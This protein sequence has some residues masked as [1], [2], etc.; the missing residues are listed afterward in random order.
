MRLIAKAQCDIECARERGF[1]YLVNC[2]TYPKILRSHWPVPGILAA[3]MKE[4]ATLASGARRRVLLQD[5][6]IIEEEI[7]ELERPF[8]HRY[9]WE[10]GLK[11]P[12]SLLVRRGEAT[13]QFMDLPCGMRVLWTYEL[14]LTSAL[15]YPI[16]KPL[17]LRFQSWMRRGLMRAKQKLER[18]RTRREEDRSDFMRSF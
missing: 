1:D 9:S 8:T 13:W 6:V 10:R 15:T 2:K 16:A 7:V 5:G 4:G 17:T 12:L 14:E 3:E 18:P 11:P